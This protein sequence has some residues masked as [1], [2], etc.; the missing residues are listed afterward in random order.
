M[1]IIV[2]LEFLCTKEGTE[3]LSETIRLAVFFIIIA[4]V[5][6]RWGYTGWC[7]RKRRRECEKRQRQK[8]ETGELITAQMLDRVRGYK[9]VLHHVYVPKADGSGTSEIDL[10]M[11]H[12]K[13]IIVVENKN[14][15]GFI[16]GAEDDLYWTQVY[17]K[18]EKRS[19]YNPVKQNQGHIRHL[20]RLLEAHI[21]NPVPYLSVITFNNEGKL[22]KIRVN[23]DTAVVTNSRKVRKCIKRRLRWQPRVLTKNQVD[24]IYYFLQNE[25]GNTRKAKKKLVK[26]IHKLQRYHVIRK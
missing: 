13:G 16:Y 1:T 5:V 7:K 4:G 8:G 10:V 25:A 17:G 23:I 18:R 26:Q 19:F 14:Y 12:E 11:I 20:K 24:E 3:N 9:R 21:Q 15:K 22:K 2:G 6:I